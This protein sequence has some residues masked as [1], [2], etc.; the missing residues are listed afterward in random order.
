RGIQYLLIGVPQLGPGAI[1]PSHFDYCDD[2]RAHCVSGNSLS[3]G[4]YRVHEAIPHPNSPSAFFHMVNTP[5]PRRRMAYDYQVKHIDE[6]ARLKNISRKTAD[7]FLKG[8]R[9]MS[10]TDTQMLRLIDPEILSEFLGDYFQRKRPVAGAPIASIDFELLAVAA[11]FGTPAILPGLTVAIDQR[12]FPEEDQQRLGYVA[13]NA[14]LGVAARDNSPESN[15]WLAS[16]IERP[17]SLT[18]LLRADL[19]AT[20]GAFLLKRHGRSPADFG[21]RPAEPTPGAAVGFR[22]RLSNVPI[23]Q[24]DSDEDRRDLS[25]WWVRREEQPAR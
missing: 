7:A 14:A 25:E 11:R 20:A 24:Y 22:S 2:K 19:G 9:A 16:V 23:H 3:P 8:D 6:A 5:T 13:W 15:A 17:D 18:P 4:D 10:V 21:L 12:R 1:R